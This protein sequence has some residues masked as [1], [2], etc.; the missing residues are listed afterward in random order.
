MAAM[1]L[2]A[3]LSKVYAQNTSAQPYINSEHMYRVPLGDISNNVTWVL[4]NHP[5]SP[6]VTYNLTDGRSDY[7]KVWVDTSLINKA[8]IDSAAVELKFIN[9]LF[10]NG[11]TWYLIFS[12][13]DS[14][15]AN[16]S[17]IARR[18]M[19]IAI[20]ENTF[21]L[22]LGGDDEDCNRLNG[23]VLN[24]DDI[25][26]NGS[27]HSGSVWPIPTYLIYRIFMHK[28][29]NFTLSTW[30]FNG[31][32]A[33]LLGNYS[34]LGFET[35]AGTGALSGTSNGGGAFT[36]TNTGAGTFSVVVNSPVNSGDIIDY[37]DIRVNLTGLVFRG[38]NARLTLSNGI[39]RSG[40]A[41]TVI[42]N[43]N[44]LYP[45]APD[46]PGDR[47]QELEIWPLPATSNIVLND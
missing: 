23:R 26:M 17:C 14:N 42:T 30:S 4:Q 47:Q 44:L 18:S 11:Q 25:L 8:T 10:V 45:I 6:T 43:D 41:Y 39:A 9:D 3:G 31:T 13:R 29:S 2:A 28:A 16:G 5:T 19:N 22:S 12:E 15:P 40:S 21:Y 46:V 1:M 34:I 20:T 37:I 36:I 32:V 27:N 24:W 35:S 33:P 7:G 38:E